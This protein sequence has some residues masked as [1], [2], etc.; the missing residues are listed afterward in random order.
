MAA[1][2]EGSIVESFFV[3]LLEGGDSISDWRGG[4]IRIIKGRTDEK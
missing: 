1:I 4:I 3:G 2:R